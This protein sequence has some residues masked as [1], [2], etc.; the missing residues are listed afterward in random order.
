[1]LNALKGLLLATTL[2]LHKSR[3][4]I[5]RIFRLLRTMPKAMKASHS[6]AQYIVENTNHMPTWIWIFWAP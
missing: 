2:S 3:M 5:P 4:I 6:V 1:M